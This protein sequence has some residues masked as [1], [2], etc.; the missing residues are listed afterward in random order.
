STKG[1]KDDMGGYT[2]GNSN[3]GHEYGAR[4]VANEADGHVDPKIRE[5]C[6]NEQIKD[7]D[8]DVSVKEKCLYPMSRQDRFD[9]LEYV[10]TL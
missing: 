4:R 1:I 10:K 7:A 5:L 9:L 8:L 3:A 2:G 6:A